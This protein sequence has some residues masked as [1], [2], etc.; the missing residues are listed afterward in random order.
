MEHTGIY[1]HLL[2]DILYTKQLQVCLAQA[3]DIKKSLDNQRGKNDKVDSVRFTEYTH[4][5]QDKAV[6][7][8]PPRKEIV[9]LRQMVLFRARFKK[10]RKMLSVPIVGLGHIAGKEI[11]RINIK[12]IHGLDRQI[13]E[14]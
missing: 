8:Q 2:L 6:L 14:V 7:W 11:E 3:I 10:V 13:K 1:T 9:K 4:R 12:I 5:F